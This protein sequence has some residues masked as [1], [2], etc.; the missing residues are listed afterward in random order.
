MT[1]LKKLFAP[2]FAA[3]ALLCAALPVQAA[4]KKA[5]PKT[6]AKKEA[7]KGKKD[8]ADSKKQPAAKKEN[9]AKEPTKGKKEAVKG[10][11]DAGQ[12]NKKNAKKEAPAKED[13]A[14]GGKKDI[15]KDKKEAAKDKS[16]N[17]KD[18]KQKTP[19]GKADEAKKKDK[20]D[21]GKKNEAGKAAQKKEPAKKEAAKKEPVTKEPAKKDTDKREGA[22][23]PQKPETPPVRDFIRRPET[24]FP[25]AAQSEA[26]KTEPGYDESA[27]QALVRQQAEKEKQKER[28]AA[29][30]AE[31]AMPS[32]SPVSRREAD[33]L[34]GSAMGLLGV[35]YRFGG[36]SVSSGF[37]C[38]GFMQHIFRKTMQ[39]NLPRTSAEQARM[40]VGVSRSE[41]QP[42][43]MVFFRTSRG[44]ISHVGLYIGNN[45]FIHAP[46]TGKSIEIT[47]LSNKYWNSRYALARRVKRF[48]SGRFAN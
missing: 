47:S 41:L 43:D 5:E 25:P 38:S 16:R 34:I 45:R 24:P 46:R 13:K 9:P 32:G 33:E 48:D 35:S 18:S 39:V 20:A 23:K 29:K 15:D 10:K 22:P 37:D 31:A 44:R 7:S 6:A 1:Y 21:T 26:P 27:M 40:G 19:A 14:K 12:E 30:T 11:K 4:N 2:A 3:L 28:Q 42:G 17:A 8:S 36:T